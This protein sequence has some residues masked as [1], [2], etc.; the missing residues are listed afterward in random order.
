MNSLV[1]LELSRN[2]LTSLSYLV[3]PNLRSLRKLNA[4][5]N[6]IELEEMDNIIAFVISMDQLQEV[7]LYGN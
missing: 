5:H 7:D 6:K 4:S 3:L 1:T 2:Q